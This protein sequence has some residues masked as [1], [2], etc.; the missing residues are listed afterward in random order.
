MLRPQEYFEVGFQR[1][2]DR[3]SAGNDPFARRE[4]AIAV[5]ADE[6]DYSLTTS[7]SVSGTFLNQVDLALGGSNLHSVAFD[8]S[9]IGLKT[10]V[11]TITSTSQGVEGSLLTIPVSFTVVLPLF[12]AE[13]ENG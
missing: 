1:G 11:I 5:G 13:S 8:T 7:G 2:Q 12:Q 3:S 4:G 9:T 6:L 10:G